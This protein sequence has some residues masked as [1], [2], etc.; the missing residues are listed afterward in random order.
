MSEGTEQSSTVIPSTSRRTSNGE[1]VISVTGAI[2]YTRKI[3]TQEYSFDGWKINV[4]KSPILPSVCYCNILDHDNTKEIL[5]E[6]GRSIDTVKLANAQ[7]TDSSGTADSGNQP[8]VKC[9]VCRYV[10]GLPFVFTSLYFLLNW[11]SEY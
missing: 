11:T 10:L 7:T 9:Q 5:L 3:S 1:S 6:L 2:Q 4:L 8:L